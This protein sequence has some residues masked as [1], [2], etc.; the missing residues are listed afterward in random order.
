M[1][2]LREYHRLRVLHDGVMWNM[3][4]LRRRECSGFRQHIVLYMNT[5]V[6]EKH[7]DY[8]FKM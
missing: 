2:D 7:A 4:G 6:S 5:D 3:L 1:S 8:F